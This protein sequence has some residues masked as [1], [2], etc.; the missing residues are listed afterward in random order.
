MYKVL[1]T[2]PL[3]DHGLRQLTDARDVEVVKKIG[4]TE[5]ALIDTI[6]PYDALLV[7]SQT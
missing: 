1:V 4:L 5:L 2:D 6:P 7:R 3:S